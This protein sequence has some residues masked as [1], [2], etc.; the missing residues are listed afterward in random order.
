[1]SANNHVDEGGNRWWRKA[2][3][4]LPI[5]LAILIV[6]LMVKS[7]STPEKKE[8]VETARPMR[9]ITVPVVD[10]VPR[11]VGFGVSAPGRIWRAVS[12]VKGRVSQIH[13]DLKA[14]ALIKEGA[15]LLKINPIEYELTIRITIKIAR[16]IGIM[17]IA[18]RHHLFPPSC[19]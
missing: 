13:P 1:M 8:I 11:A 6:I 19:T 10:L 9:V 15:L 7:K 17:P 2:I 18:L 14:G 3:G 16:I 12:E 5:I 4:I